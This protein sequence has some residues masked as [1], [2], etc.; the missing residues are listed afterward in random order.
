MKTVFFIVG[1]TA[2]GKDSLT[3]A[4]AQDLNMKV[5]KSYATRPMRKDDPKDVESH[6]FIKPKEV[7]Q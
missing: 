4:V 5:L 6:I 1:R 3:N 2:S 7:K